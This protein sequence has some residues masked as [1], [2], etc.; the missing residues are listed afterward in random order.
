MSGFTLFCVV[1]GVVVMVNQL[2][3]IEALI[4]NGAN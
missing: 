3:A 2:F 1:I 4:E